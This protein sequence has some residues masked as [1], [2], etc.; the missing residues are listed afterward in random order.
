MTLKDIYDNRSLLEGLQGVYRITNIINGK[1]YVGQSKDI[2]K[3]IKGHFSNCFNG[4]TALRL[5]PRMR[6]P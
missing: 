2:K 5:L 6:K 3:R 4:K 1:S